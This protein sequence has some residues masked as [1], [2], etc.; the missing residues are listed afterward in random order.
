MPRA[1][2]PKELQGEI[3]GGGTYRAC[4]IDVDWSDEPLPVYAN[5]AQLVHTHREFAVA[6]TEFA[7]FAGRR[8]KPY[9]ARQGEIH[10]RARVVSAV[11]LPPDV[12]FQFL[13]AA[14]S[15]WNK[16]VDAFGE[17]GAQMPKFKLIR[18]GELQLENVGDEEA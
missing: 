12:F 9:P 5:G 7:P 13:A 1:D 14:T 17:A 15:N 16:F 8:P 11:R 6:F 10:E 2:L 18:S 4:Q 3:G